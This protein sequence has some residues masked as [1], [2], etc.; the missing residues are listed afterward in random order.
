MTQQPSV[1]RGALTI[2][3]R[4]LGE[5]GLTSI[6]RVIYCLTVCGLGG[7]GRFAGR[8]AFAAHSG[9]HSSDVGAD[10]IERRSRR[11]GDDTLW[12]VQPKRVGKACVHDRPTV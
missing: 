8:P 6:A 9:G 12:P 3:G 5:E 2:T 7:L 4:A 10:S 11:I 1:A